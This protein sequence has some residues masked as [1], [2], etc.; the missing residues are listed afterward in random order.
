MISSFL[1]HKA[2][3]R[4]QSRVLA[5]NPFTLTLFALHRSLCLSLSQRRDT[6]S[7]SSMSR[8][9]SVLGLPHTTTSPSFARAHSPS[10]SLSSAKNNNGG[11]L[12]TSDRSTMAN[13]RITMDAL[14]SGTRYGGD[15]SLEAQLGRKE[16]E[17][18]K[19]RLARSASSAVL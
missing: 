18:E 1:S 3:E 15:E 19:V 7:T 12:D 14:T 17:V 4:N 10:N 13:R 2:N 5:I 16:R 6:R 11:Y 9:Q 8:R